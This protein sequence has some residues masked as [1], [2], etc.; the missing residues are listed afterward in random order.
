MAVSAVHGGGVTLLTPT[1]FLQQA[2]GE[3][4][5]DDNF[6]YLLHAQAPLSI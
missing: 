1:T 3:I 6:V 4:F 2:S 5:K